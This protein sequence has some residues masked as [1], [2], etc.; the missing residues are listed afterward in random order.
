MLFRPSPESVYLVFGV[1]FCC[2]CLFVYLCLFACL[3]VCVCFCCC[4]CCYRRRCCCC[5][6]F[7]CLHILYVVCFFFVYFSCLQLFLLIQS[8]ILLPAQ[9]FTKKQHTHTHASYFAGIFW[10]RNLAFLLFLFSLVFQP[11]SF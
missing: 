11:L 8:A 3:F 10:S 2:L 7:C 9:S 5:Y 1:G 6:I 4:R